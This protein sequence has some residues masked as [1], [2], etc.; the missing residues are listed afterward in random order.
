MTTYYR[1]SKSEFEVETERY[2][3]SV[4]QV[5]NTNLMTVD[6]NTDDEIFVGYIDLKDSPEQCLAGLSFPF[7]WRDED[8]EAIKKGILKELETIE[9]TPYE[10]EVYLIKYEGEGH[11]A[12]S[13][14]NLPLDVI[15]DIAETTETEIYKK[16]LPVSRLQELKDVCYKVI[17]ENNEI[18]SII[19]PDKDD[20]HIEGY[21][22]P[23]ETIIKYHVIGKFGE[24][25]TDHIGGDLSSFDLAV[26]FFRNLIL[27][28]YIAKSD[29]KGYD[30][31]DL[32][33][34]KLV[35]AHYTIVNG[36]ECMTSCEPISSYKI[37]Y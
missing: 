18:K 11:T 29:E 36:D 24:G 4:C 23:L 21:E 2:L 35:E 16:D 3:V 34:L 12:V 19:P 17:V 8:V 30:I 1:L 22:K 13:I 28:R 33:E 25:K 27:Y 26:T 6:L 14:R 31:S 7:N 32:T 15:K 37:R 5:E 20:Y 10:K 9:I